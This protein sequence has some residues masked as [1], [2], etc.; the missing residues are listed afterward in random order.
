M[1]CKH[2]LSEQFRKK[3]PDAVLQYCN[4]QNAPRPFRDLILRAIHDFLQDQPPLQTAEL[5]TFLHDL[6]ASQNRIGWHLFMRGMFSTRWKKY[7]EDCIRRRPPIQ[8]AKMRREPNSFLAGLVKTMWA[9]MSDFWK[10]HCDNTHK[11]ADTGPSP[12]KELEFKNRIR[13]LYSKKHACLAAHRETFFHH[14]LNDYLRHAMYTQ[15]RNYI[16]NYEPAIYKSIKRAKQAHLKSS[17]LQ[18]HTGFTRTRPNQPTIPRD[19]LTSHVANEVPEHPQ[20]T[21]WR[22]LAQAATAFHSYF[23]PST[24]PNPD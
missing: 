10:K 8:S 18:P 24:N 16:D 3:L 22:P 5:P 4:E 15:L 6:I 9:Q 11:K 14:N 13:F 19:P 7:L 1:Q 21:R 12:E 2:S 23:H 17:V 20:H